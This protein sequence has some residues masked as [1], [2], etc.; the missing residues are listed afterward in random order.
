MASRC[1]G[2]DRPSPVQRPKILGIV[3]IDCEGGSSNLVPEASD[4]L[5]SEESP[6][7]YK[8]MGLKALQ[9]A[10][11]ALELSGDVIGFPKNGIS[12]S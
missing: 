8:M 4:S 5:D 9:G 3:G 7:E 12:S 6:R 11:G 1:L 10:D 2:A